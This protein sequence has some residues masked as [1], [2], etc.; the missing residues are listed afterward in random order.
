MEK[1]RAFIG[2]VV[3]IL[4]PFFAVGAVFDPHGFL[5]A[6]IVSALVAVWACS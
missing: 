4:I 3:L 1:V 2:V 6:T 5:P